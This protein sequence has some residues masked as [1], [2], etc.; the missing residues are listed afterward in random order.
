MM[1]NQHKKDMATSDVNAPA[2]ASEEPK[3]QGTGFKVVSPKNKTSP[4]QVH[5]ND[6]SPCVG[7][8]GR[9]QKGSTP[10]KQ[11]AEPIKSINTQTVFNYSMIVATRPEP[12]VRPPSR[13][14]NVRP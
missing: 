1:Q 8:A 7:F 11:R 14:A 12:T 13:I 6:L 3:P 2:E 4:Q 5:K 10:C 9:T